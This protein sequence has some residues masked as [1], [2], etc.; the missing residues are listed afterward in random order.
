[1]PTEWLVVERAV[2]EKNDKKYRKIKM[3]IVHTIEKYADIFCN[4]SDI[5]T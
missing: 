4:V 5:E 1:M 3:C 2:F